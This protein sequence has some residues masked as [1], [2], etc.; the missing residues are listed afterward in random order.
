MF[1]GKRSVHMWK[2]YCLSLLCESAGDRVKFRTFLFIARVY[3]VYMYGTYSLTLKNGRKSLYDAF[4]RPLL[5]RLNE[6]MRRQVSIRSR[7][8]SPD[9]ETLFS[10][11]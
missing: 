3:E 9:S 5:Q 7:M 8:S 10:D 11:L 6:T 1:K 2:Q 4:I